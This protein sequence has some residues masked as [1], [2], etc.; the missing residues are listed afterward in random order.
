MEKTLVDELHELIFDWR[1]VQ[2]EGEI[3]LEHEEQ[4]GGRDPWKEGYIHAI[5]GAE[6][7]LKEIL[8]RHH[9]S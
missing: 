4:R 8:K 1:R 7:R 5:E 3:M 2:G 6:H 9:G